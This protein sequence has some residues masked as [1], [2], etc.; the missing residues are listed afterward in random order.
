MNDR[1]AATVNIQRL[2]GLLSEIQD[3]GAITSGMHGFYSR[4]D[5]EA[6]RWALNRLTTLGFPHVTEAEALRGGRLWI[7][8]ESAEVLLREMDAAI[9]GADA[10]PKPKL[11]DLV[12]DVKRLVAR[13]HETGWDGK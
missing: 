9:N 13:A 10:V 2:E 1:E 12:E 11:R 4:D 6:I 5:V 3:A 7:D 8:A